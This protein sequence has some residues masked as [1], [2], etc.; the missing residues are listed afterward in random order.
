VADR[1]AY[2][3]SNTNVVGLS[4][5]VTDAD[6]HSDSFCNADADP[7]T[8]TD[9]DTHTYAHTDTHTNAHADT[10]TNAH[11]DPNTH[12]NANTLSSPGLQPRLCHRDGEQGVR[13]RDR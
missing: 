7:N 8:H 4:E 10:N 3:E 1:Q 5:P 12:A 11:T 13:E 6:R 2:S 9:T